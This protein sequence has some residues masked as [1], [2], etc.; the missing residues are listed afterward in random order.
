MSA[1]VLRSYAPGPLYSASHLC[2]CSFCDYFD[3]RDAELNQARFNWLHEH[4]AALGGAPSWDEMAGRK[5]AR[6]V[7]TSEFDDNAMTERWPEMVSWLVEQQIRFREALAAVGGI[8]AL[9]GLDHQE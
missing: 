7:V 5:G 3:S 9:R 2:R 6:I 8:A 1:C 4:R